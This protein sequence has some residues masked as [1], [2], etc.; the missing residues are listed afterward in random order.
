MQE[1]SDVYADTFIVAIITY[2]VL[3]GLVTGWLVRRR[4]LHGGFPRLL[5]EAVAATVLVSGLYV[6]VGMYMNGISFSRW[7]ELFVQLTFSSLEFA[8][9]PYLIGAGVSFFVEL[10]YSALRYRGRRSVKA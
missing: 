6:T 10:L 4:V 2:A 8:Y 1:V 7:L 5:A 9:W 3:L